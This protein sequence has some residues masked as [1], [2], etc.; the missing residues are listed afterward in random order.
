MD[1][2]RAL[3]G[4]AIDQIENPCD[5]EYLRLKMLGVSNQDI[6]AAMGLS[7]SALDTRACRLR[8]RLRSMVEGMQ[9]E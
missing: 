8:S 7:Q 1:N 6:A 4:K 3:M 9:Q 2:D 5:R